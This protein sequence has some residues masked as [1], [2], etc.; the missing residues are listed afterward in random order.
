[1][2][3]KRQRLIPQQAT[4]GEHPVDV[5][6][7]LISTGDQ[8]DLVAHHVRDDAGE[9]RVVGAPEDEG[10]DARLTQGVEIPVCSGQHLWAAGE[11]L[12]DVLDELRASL[13][14]HLNPRGR[15]KGVHVGAG[16]DGGLG[17]DDSDVAVAGGVHGAAHRR[18]DDLDDRDAVPLPGITQHGRARTVARDDEH[19]DALLDEVVHHVEREGAHLG[20]RP[21]AVGAAGGIA[22]VQDRLVRQQVEHRARHRQPA[23]TT[24]EDAD[25]C[26]RHRASVTARWP[27]HREATVR[28]RQAQSWPSIADS[29]ASRSMAS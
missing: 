22:H 1:M 2:R 18:L 11:P 9:Q 23:D 13:L 28:S 26:V 14:S 27:L 15:G 29:A 8:R 7:G 6:S 17:A 24:V 3:R 10:V 25:R 16:C 4:L 21:G 20:D 5:T 19:L 12:F